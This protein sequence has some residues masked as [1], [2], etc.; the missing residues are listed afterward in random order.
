MFKL[1]THI[2][3]SETSSCGILSAPQMAMAYKNALYDGIVIT[4][5][6]YKDFFEK[7]SQSDWEDKIKQYL[8]GYYSALKTG[9][10]IGLKVFF[11][12]ELRLV[13][14][15]NDYLVYGVDEEFLIKNPKLYEYSPLEMKKIADENGI[16]IFQAHPFRP[17]MV[18]MGSDVIHGVEVYNGNTNHNSYNDLAYKYAKNN[19]LFMISGSDCHFIEGVG[20]G[21]VIL[22]NEIT[23]ESELPVAL[24]NINKELIRII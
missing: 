12:L 20:R 23:S 1:D 5:H 6:Y 10:E 24:K 4:D 19:S 8:K 11:G 18:C 21:G 16:V 14:S 3:T 9:E 22:E 15:N 13:E 7:L 17:G 2:H